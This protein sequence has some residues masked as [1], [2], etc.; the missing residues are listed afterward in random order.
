MQH[1]PFPYNATSLCHVASFYCY[2]C[3]LRQRKEKRQGVVW[4]V[5]V[6]PLCL[7]VHAGR[8]N[9]MSVWIWISQNLSMVTSEGVLPVTSFFLYWTHVCVC[10]Y[11]LPCEPLS[12]WRTVWLAVRAKKNMKF[13]WLFVTGAYLRDSSCRTLLFFS[14]TV[15]MYPI[16]PLLKQMQLFVY[17]VHL[18]RTG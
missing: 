8:C 12:Q 4:T 1:K 3:V 17:Y 10:V 15:I 13:P 11:I 7:P 6:Y 2:P 5:S 18:A 9:L 16:T 14:L